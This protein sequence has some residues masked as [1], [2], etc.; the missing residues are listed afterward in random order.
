ML[1][2]AAAIGHREAVSR[3]EKPDPTEALVL[4]WQPRA[5]RPALAALFALD[6]RLAGVVSRAREPMLAQVRLAWWREQLGEGA[7][8]V[9]AGE[10]LLAELAAHWGAKTAEL[11]SLIDGWEQLLGD[12]PLDDSPL[13][14]F[15]DGRGRALAAFAVL[16]GAGEHR[17]AVHA[18]GRCW[19]LADMASRS[20][21]ARERELARSLGRNEP[22]APIRPR[23]LRGVAVLGGLS[24][25]ALQRG[26]PLLEGRGAALAAMRLG[27][28]GG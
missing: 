16:A 25:L 2:T 10:P 22:I 26:V 28:F 21:D 14:G 5:S 12:A 20:S 8:A 23:S 19:A 3:A 1:A 24:R 6:Q 13:N 27:L 7:S 9:A 4:A 17:Y 11:Q 15:A 18:A